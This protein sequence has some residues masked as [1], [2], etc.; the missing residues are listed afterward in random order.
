MAKI[1]FS[2]GDQF[3]QKLD[4]LAQIDV[5]GSIRKAVGRGAKTVA[6]AV[7]AALDAISTQKATHLADGNKLHAPLQ[8]H[9]KRDLQA[10]LGITPVKTDKSGFTNARVGWDG[11]GSR[12]TKKYPKGVPNRLIAGSVERGS[13]VR[14]AHPFVKPTVTKIRK[15]A[16]AVME[17]SIDSDVAEIFEN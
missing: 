9:E 7:R 17:E 6:D 14:R 4:A 15:Q 12:P 16:V 11:Y 3:G 10:A 5:R 1:S 2:S 8:E 13:S